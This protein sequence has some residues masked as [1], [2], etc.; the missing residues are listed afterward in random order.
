MTFLNLL[1][2]QLNTDTLLDRLS[3]NYD[4]EWIPNISSENATQEIS[5]YSFFDVNINFSRSHDLVKSDWTN[6]TWSPY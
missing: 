2:K 1:C 6:E 5:L 4:T 3:A